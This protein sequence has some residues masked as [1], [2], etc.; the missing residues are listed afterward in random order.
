LLGGYGRAGRYDSQQSDIYHELVNWHL[1]RLDR[2]MMRNRV[3]VRSPFLARRV[4][5]AAL[6]LPRWQ[7]T[8]KKILRDLF[9]PELGDL[10]DVPKKPLRTPEVE[11]DRESET[12]KLV[13]EFMRRW[14]EK[15]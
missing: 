15:F 12:L 5:E 14:C 9:R 7:R 4:V 10:V 11:R 13:K 3:E 8:Y 2:V 1:P 6:G